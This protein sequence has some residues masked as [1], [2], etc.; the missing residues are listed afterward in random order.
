M[1]VQDQRGDRDRRSIRGTRQSRESSSERGRD[2]SSG[3]EERRGRPSDDGE[4]KLDLTTNGRLFPTWAAMKFKHLKLPEIMRDPSEDPC[5]PKLDGSGKGKRELRKYQQFLAEYMSYTSQHKRMLLWWGLGAGKTTGIINLYNMLYHHNPNWNVFILIKAALRDDPWIKE[6]KAWMRGDDVKHMYE[7]IHFV[8]YDSPFAQ[9]DFIDEVRHSDASKPNMYFIDEAHNFIL[10]TYSNVTTHKG[11]R[12]QIIYDH[13]QQDVRENE[14]TR[15]V[16]ISATPAVNNPFELALIY[17]LLRPGIFPKSESEFNEQFLSSGHEKALDLSKRNQFQRLILGL[18]S[19]YIGTTPDTHATSNINYVDMPMERHQNEVYRHFEELESRAAMKSGGAGS[20]YRSYTRQ[21]CNFVFPDID[22][23]ITGMKRPR[24]AKFRLNMREAQKLLEGL[25]EEVKLKAEGDRDKF[26]NITAYLDAIK[27]Y[28]EGTKKWFQSF[29]DKDVADGYTIHDDIKLCKEKYHSRFEKFYRKE[30]R[31]SSLFNAMYQCSP[32][33][34]HMLFKVMLT[35]GKS[36]MYSNYVKMEGLEMFKMYLHLAGFKQWKEG[37]KGKLT[38]GEFH[39]DIERD[40]RR[41]FRDAYNEHD[42]TYGENMRVF[43]VSPAGAEGLSLRSTKTVLL[44]EP[45][46]HEVRLQQ[47]IGRAIRQCSHV[48]L[49]MK[50]RHVE[51]YRYR[52][53]RP[54]G[55]ETTDVYI[56]SVARAKQ[57]LVESFLEAARES[58]VDCV[59]NQAHNMMNQPYKCFSFDVPSIFDKNPGPAYNMDPYTNAKLDNGLNADNSMVVRVKA[60]KVK[61]V[62]SFGEGKYSAPKDYWLYVDDGLL[63]DSVLKIPIAKAARDESGALVKVDSN[64]YVVSESVAGI[65]V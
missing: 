46:W 51:I 6:L 26:M 38:Y 40:D 61:A 3:A 17:N 5:K 43:L 56:E 19:Y 53:V 44:A 34:T 52:M 1:G 18:T 28:T 16:A 14:T 9:R 35:N 47:M 22:N 12:A 10:N 2:N 59:I 48:D 54:G 62:K 49:P 15:V 8:H 36:V 23:R 21:A 45:H 4:F 27:E 32:K 37:D 29:A 64:T 25:T 58:A 31:K 63:F 33:F 65:D 42:N 39:G 7:N 11:N 20:M 55:G 41:V 13:I 24:P 30:K 50:E 60:L 57:N